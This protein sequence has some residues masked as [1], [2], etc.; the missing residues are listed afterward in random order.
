MCEPCESV[1]R[2]RESQ[3]HRLRTAVL[4]LKSTNITVIYICLKR[5][6]FLQWSDTGYINHSRTRLIFRSSCPITDSTFCV[7][8]CM[9]MF[10]FG[11]CLVVFF[12]SFGGI[13]LLCFLALEGVIVFCCFEK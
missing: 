5:E 13:V 9:D 3:P 8:A 4:G 10:L 7:C 2:P 11:K 6:S 12:L 1:I